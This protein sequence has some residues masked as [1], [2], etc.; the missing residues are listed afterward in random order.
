MRKRTERPDEGGELAKKEDAKNAAAYSAV[1]ADMDLHDFVTGFRQKV[2][3]FLWE[4]GDKI[5]IGELVRLT[6][7]ERETTRQSESKRPREL[8]IVWLRNEQQ[9]L[10]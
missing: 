2:Q 9:S 7:L 6:E 5:T 10:S 3:G 1:A 4:R 8:R